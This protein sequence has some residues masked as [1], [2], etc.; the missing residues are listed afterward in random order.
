M[1][2]SS[3]IE[4]SF[5]LMLKKYKMFYLNACFDLLVVTTRTVVQCSV[6]VGLDMV[7]CNDVCHGHHLEKG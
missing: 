5:D 4:K 1:M 7:R 6:K 2:K 3:V